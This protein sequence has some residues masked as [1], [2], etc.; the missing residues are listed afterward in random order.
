MKLPAL[1][2]LSEPVKGKFTRWQRGEV[3]RVVG[4]H[5]R[6]YSLEKL[7]PKGLKRGAPPLPLFNQISNVPRTAL[8]FH[9]VAK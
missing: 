9:E 1:A 2:T 6:R 8:R 5:R 7:K 4:C 3:V